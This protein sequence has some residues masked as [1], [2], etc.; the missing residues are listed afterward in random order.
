[1]TELLVDVGATSIKWTYSIDGEI[2]RVRRRSTPR[3]C[4]PDRLVEMIVHRARQ[5][6]CT[7]VAIGF[8]GEMRDGVVVDGANLVRQDGPFS[9]R[10][11]E[12]DEAWRAFPLARTIR[13][14]T[15][16]PVVAINDAHAIALGCDV[17]DGRSLVVVLGTGCGVGLLED[18]ALV[19]IRDYGDERIGEM[20]LDQ[21]VGEQMRRRGHDQW[22]S[23]CNEV[24]AY[25]IAETNPDAVYLAGGNAG[26][27]RPTD[28]AAVVPSVLVRTEP[29]F[30]G[31]LKILPHAI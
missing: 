16:Q 22:L 28:I 1:M 30:R 10:D 31:L 5:R 6:Q 2:E 25:L 21:L 23:H 26:R 11:D 14:Q 17:Q 27:L 29:A 20:T 3:P 7:A 18:G 12:L 8:P 9:P 15:H 4:T 13:E 24:V 19:P